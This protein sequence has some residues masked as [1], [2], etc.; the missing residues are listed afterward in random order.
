MEGVSHMTCM[1]TV[2]EESTRIQIGKRRERNT[3]HTTHSYIHIHIHIHTCTHMHTRTH[4]PE[5]LTHETTHYHTLLPLT[6][7]PSCAQL[8]PDCAVAVAATLVRREHTA[9]RPQPPTTMKMWM[10]TVLLLVLVMVMTTR[11]RTRTRRPMTPLMSLLRRSE[12][13]SRRPPADPHRRDRVIATRP[14]WR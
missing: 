5:E 2:L 14:T 4:T 13:R 1:S 12:V 9:S 6:H 3:Q 10:V 7:Q 8:N 11:M